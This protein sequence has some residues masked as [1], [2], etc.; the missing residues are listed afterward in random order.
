MSALTQ[1]FGVTGS[2][3]SIDILKVEEKNCWIRFPSEDL[4]TV[5]AALEGWVGFTET[6]ESFRWSVKRSGNWLGI[7]AGE[8]DAGRLW[9]D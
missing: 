3:V 5:L 9:S 7:L 2:A 8:E 4:S 1:Y 6:D